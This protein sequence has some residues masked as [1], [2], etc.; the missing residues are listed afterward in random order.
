M[1]TC[2]TVFFSIFFFFF[3]ERCHSCCFYPECRR[4]TFTTTR[5]RHIQIFLFVWL[6]WRILYMGDHS[7]FSIYCSLT[8]VFLRQVR[9]NASLGEVQPAVDMH[10]CSFAVWSV[11][12]LS[13]LLSAVRLGNVQLVVAVLLHTINGLACVSFDIVGLWKGRLMLTLNMLNLFLEN[14]KIIHALTYL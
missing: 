11:E 13:Q 1:Q 4:H 14:I 3:R 5:P 7:K 8:L 9:V 12:G 10:T 6:T 2:L